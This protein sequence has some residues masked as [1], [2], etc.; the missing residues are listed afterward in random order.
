VRKGIAL[1]QKVNV[2]FLGLVEIMSYY[3]TPTGDRIELFGH[4]GGKAEAARQ[5]A[6]FLGEVPIYVEIREGGD[7][8]QPIVVTSLNSAPGR[9]FLDIAINVRKQLMK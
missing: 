7:A 5:N 1:F 9:A 2:P 6:P 8:G 4:G 3:T